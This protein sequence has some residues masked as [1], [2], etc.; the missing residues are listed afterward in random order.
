V[1]PI[2]AARNSLSAAC[3]VP[4]VSLPLWKKLPPI[5][6]WLVPGAVGIDHHLGLDAPSAC[7]SDSTLIAKFPEGDV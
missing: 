1:Q 7:T 5:A 3:T 2:V 4:A 6:Y